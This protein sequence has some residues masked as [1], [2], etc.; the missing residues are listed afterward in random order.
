M[1]ETIQTQVYKI[2][3]DQE[4]ACSRQTLPTITINLVDGVSKVLL[5][6]VE[7]VMHVVAQEAIASQAGRGQSRLIDT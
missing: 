4:K 6:T 7:V 3:S 2:F 1:K 5:V